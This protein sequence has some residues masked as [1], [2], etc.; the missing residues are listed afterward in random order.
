MTLLNNKLFLLRAKKKSDF[1]LTSLIYIKGNEIDI[2]R[3]ICITGII[4]Y[5]SQTKDL[6]TVPLSQSKIVG[7]DYNGTVQII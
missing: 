7:N 6:Y 2:M 5:I 1:N 4:N 3:K